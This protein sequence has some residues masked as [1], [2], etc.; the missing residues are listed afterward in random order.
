MVRSPRRAIALAAV[1]AVAGSACSGS[2][3][4]T[5]PTATSGTIEP[6]ATTA[7]PTTVSPATSA[8]ATTAPPAATTAPSSVATTAPPP[9]TLPPTTTTE[10]LAVQELVLRGDALGSAF[11]GAAPDGVIDY[12]TSILGGNTG[13]TG[14][15]DP[16][17]FA[18]CDGTIARRV[19]WGVLSLLFGDQ[20]SFANGRRHFI[21]YEYGRVGQIGDEPEGLRTPGGVTL[22]SR[23]VDL[24]AEFPDAGVN[25]GEDD[26]NIP[27][28]FYVSDVFYGLITGTS[29][30]DVVTVV[31]GGNGCGE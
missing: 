12:V 30:D 11:F 1:V 8:P 24:L 14:W 16:F 19:D 20:S 29:Q 25:D 22:G 27:P 13:D 6:V 3:Q 17:T 21:G 23:V 4:A 9:T 10:P 26:L 18:A 28:N 7:P 5:A 2:E 15:V 31:F